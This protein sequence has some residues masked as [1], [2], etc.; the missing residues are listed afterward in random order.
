MIQVFQPLKVGDG[1]T[2]S[3]DVHVGDNETTP[4]LKNLIGCWRNWTIC[5]FSDNLGLHLLGISFVYDLLHGSRNQDVTLLVHQVLPSVRFGV[6]EP[7]NCAMLQFV[8]LQFSWVDACWR[9]DGSVPLGHPNAG[10]A[11]PVEVA[12]GV[13][14]D[15][16][17]ALDDE[18]LATPPWRLPDHRHELGLV[19]E[20]LEAVEDPSTSGGH[21][22]VDTALVNRLPGHAG[23]RVHVL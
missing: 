20:V 8:I 10:G 5:G 6:G 7:N 4:V 11:G 15:V 9:A 23:R 21:P 19:D 17:E 3:I 1:D 13:E 2:T 12:H 18:G 22:A 16:A 14:P